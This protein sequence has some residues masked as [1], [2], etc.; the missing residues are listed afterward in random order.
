LISSY[1]N[2][3]S[4]SAIGPDGSILLR[5]LDVV[6]VIVAAP[7]LILIGVSAAGYAAGA[8]AWLLLRALGAGLERYLVGV[9]EPRR[10]ISLRLAYL[11]A[12]VFMLALA[13]VLVRRADGKDA[14]LATLA[15]IVFA[16]TVQLAV[17]FLQR[18]RRAR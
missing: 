12:R 17:S 9:S 7:I 11:I 16:F 3:P 5:Y 1:R 8:G 4:P 2:T 14:A 15:V 18:P 6:L 13:I 10:E